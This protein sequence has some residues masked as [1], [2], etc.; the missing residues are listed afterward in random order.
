MGAVALQHD[1]WSDEEVTKA[2][3]SPAPARVRPAVLADVEP[4]VRRRYSVMLVQ[5]C[6]LLV[7]LWVLRCLA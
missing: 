1:D 2:E 7:A 4:A 6:G 3:S 5:L